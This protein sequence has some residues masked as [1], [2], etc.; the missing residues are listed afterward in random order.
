MSEKQKTIKSPVSVSGVGLHTGL[1]ITLT[2]NPAPPNHGIKFKRTD[3]NNNVI[4]DADVDLV[5]DTSRGTSIE[6]EG[7]R[8]DT[9][10]HVMAA[11]TGLEI[12][13]VLIEMNQSETPI[14]D[15][16]ARFYVEALSSAGTVEQNAPRKYFE[17]KEIIIYTNP[18]KKVEMI[19]M[20][21]KDYRLSVMIDYESKVLHSQNAT[22]NDIR[23]F[24]DEISRCRTFVFLHEME[25]LLNNNLIKGGDLSNAIVFVNRAVSKEELDHLAGSFISPRWKCCPVKVS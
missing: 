7:S 18:E 2:F 9:I 1:D 14:L 20:P 13:N 10:E 17:L 23:K 8:F 5:V 24:K 19:A 16:S 11:L 22:L 21:D 12:D 4:V 15:G 6:Y 25:Y 3:L